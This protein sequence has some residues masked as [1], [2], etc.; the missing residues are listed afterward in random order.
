LPKTST[1]SSVDTA[2]SAAQKLIGPG[3]FFPWPGPSFSPC[4]ERIRH[5]EYALRQKDL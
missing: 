2:S 4:G 3:S 1:A 5:L